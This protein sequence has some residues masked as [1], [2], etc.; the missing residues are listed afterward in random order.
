MLVAQ[1]RGSDKQIDQG[2]QP[3][4]GQVR[5]GEKYNHALDSPVAQRPVRHPYRYR[6]GEPIL[7][8]AMGC[9]CTEISWYRT[10]GNRDGAARS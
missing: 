5:N 8:G 3:E 6:K 9:P 2:M 1:K 7:T 4:Q 10:M